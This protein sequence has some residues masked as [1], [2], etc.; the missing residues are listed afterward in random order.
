MAGGLLHS[1]AI[2]LGIIAHDGVT[3]FTRRDY[4]QVNQ[5]LLPTA[6][7]LGRDGLPSASLVEAI[8]AAVKEFS[9]DLVHI[10]GTESFWGLLHARGLLTYSALLEIQ[11]LKGQIAKVVFGGLTL[12]ERL[13]CTGIKELLKRRTI[14]A[15]RRD[16]ARWGLHEEEIIRSQRFVDVQSPWVA[17]HVKA[18]NPSA[19][20]FQVNLAL[21]KPFY[22]A[23]AWQ[24]PLRPTIFCSAAYTSPFKGL[25]VAVRALGLLRKHIPDVRLRIAGAHQQAG[26]RQS[27]YMRWVNRM[28]GQLA[29]GD[30]IE[31]LG[32]LNAEQIVTELKNAATV[33]IPSFVESYCLALAEAMRVG[34]PTV[35]AYTGG[36]GHLGKDE[37]SC[38]FFPPG[39][40]AMCAHQLERVLTDVELA[41]RLSRESRKIAAVRNDCQR[42]VQQ[43]LEI[44]RQVMKESEKSRSTAHPAT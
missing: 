10:W 9:P 37:E 34:T 40:E 31:W 29:M 19:R 12:L 11:G 13:Q 25:H 15:D 21:R 26:I 27:G 5:W 43:Q 6:A 32:P 1:E 41:V 8:L 36:T 42:I 33:V 24:S 16:F 28:I 22:D 18:I 30:A 4:R 2:E 3:Q 20:L 35:V 38:L 7:R 44:Y 17:S 39:D 23:D 14:Y